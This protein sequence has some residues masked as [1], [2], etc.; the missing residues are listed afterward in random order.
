MPDFDSDLKRLLDV[1]GVEVVKEKIAGDIDLAMRVQSRG[2]RGP[3]EIDYIA[4]LNLGESN[5]NNNDFSTSELNLIHM[6]TAGI[7][8]I[9]DDAAI[10]VTPL[11][12][13]TEQSMQI[14]RDWLVIQRDPTVFL[15]NFKSEGQKLLLAARLQG[16]VKTAY[17]DGKHIDE[18]AEDVEREDPNFIKAGDIHV[19]L[20]A[21]TDILSDIFW[22]RKQNYFGVSAPQPIANNGD[23]VVNSIDNLSG[24]NDLISL[25]SRGKYSRPFEL[26]EAIRKEAEAKFRERERELQ[27]KLNE[28]EQ[29]IQQLQQEQGEKSAYILTAEQQKEIEEFRQERLKTRKQLRAVQHELQKNI[30]RLGSQLRFINIGLI[31]LL[32]IILALITGIYRAHRRI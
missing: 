7:I 20:V 2:V 17:P 19:I 30:E 10:S 31:P 11:I 25:R 16:H 22:V 8:N 23:F 14:N 29:K 6:G 21:D 9:K 18:T 32:I 26:V 24:N 27:A 3:Q 5:F 4:W 28:T 15:E 13:T 1:W 12:Q